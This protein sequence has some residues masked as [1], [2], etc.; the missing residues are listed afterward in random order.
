MGDFDIVPQT[1][2]S[3]GIN[4]LFDRVAVQPG[5]P[6]TFGTGAECFFFGLPGNPVS[7]FIQFELMVRPFLMRRMGA[8]FIPVSLRLPLSHPFTRKQAER[9]AHLPAVINPLGSCTLI[10]YHGSGH[11][12][13]LDRAQAIVRIPVGVTSVSAGEQVEVILL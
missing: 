3:L 1:A 13:A 5:K 2:Q 7:S 9:M 8:Q 12:T 6:T 10:D 4:I 11:I